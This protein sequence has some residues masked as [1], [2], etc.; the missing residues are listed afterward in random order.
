[1]LVKDRDYRVASWKDVFTMCQE[2]ED[3][4]RFKPRDTT[5]ANSSISL[6]D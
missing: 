2:I 3:G 1:M 6:I 5:N 4:A